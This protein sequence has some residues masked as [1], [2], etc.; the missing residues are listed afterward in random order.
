MNPRE[1]RPSAGAA[2]TW[3][4]VLATACS[5]SSAKPS[6]AGAPDGVSG[7]AAADGGVADAASESGGD[8]GVAT[9]GSSIV[10]LQLLGLQ[11]SI[12]DILATFDPHYAAGLGCAHTVSGPCT[13]D[14]C[15]ALD[16]QGGMLLGESAGTLTVSGAL[17]PTT[18][19]LHP[20]DAGT[21]R[22][23][24][25][26][27]PLFAMGNVFQVSAAGDVFPAFTGQSANAPALVAI[28]SP[29]MT[30]GADGPTY[31]YDPTTA[32]TWTWTGGQMGTSVIVSVITHA[33][34]LT[35]TCTFDATAGTGTI[36]QDVVAKLPP[37]SSTLQIVAASSTML[38]AGSQSVLFELETGGEQTSLV[39]Q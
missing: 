12:G 37:M 8:S 16:M 11:G 32:L 30:T 21:Y 34:D 38:A 6:D 22:V 4:V 36:P 24:L 7:D 17:L 35:V 9:A 19:M 26:G 25:A 10:I 3:L 15:T 27:N 18:L 39:A 28:T 1:S 33:P 13:I 14:D 20:G 31:T 2:C 5:S 29:A 23:P